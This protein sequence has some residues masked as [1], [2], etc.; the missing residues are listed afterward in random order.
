MTN[1]RDRLRSI[2]TS[3]NFWMLNFGTTKFGASKGGGGRRVRGGGAKGKG[4]APKGGAQKG[5][6]KGETR[7]VE[8]RRVRGPKFR[9]FFSLSRHNF[10]PFFLS[11]GGLLVEFWWCLKRK[12]PE[13]CTF[14]LSELLC[15]SP[16]GPT[17]HLDS[18]TTTQIVEYTFIQNRFHPMTLSSKTTFIHP[19]STTPK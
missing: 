13:M 14:G 7:R 8:P 3:A 18:S 15:A 2:S 6:Q 19:K 9:A 12:G 10:L 16:G 17:R 11:L 4:G 1:E 5:T